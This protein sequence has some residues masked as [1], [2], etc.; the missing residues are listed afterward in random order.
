M[1]IVNENV[2]FQMIK[3]EGQNLTFVN[4]GDKLSTGSSIFI[5]IIPLQN[6][7]VSIFLKS[8]DKVNL[9]EKDILFEKGIE[10]LLPKIISPDEKFFFE[11]KKPYK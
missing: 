7:K 11:L 8:K 1:W 4:E 5:R 9:L 2:S 10:V 3:V 6:E